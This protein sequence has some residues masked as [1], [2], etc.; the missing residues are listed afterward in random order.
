MRK[1]TMFVGMM[2]MLCWLPL[3][4]R[5]AAAQNEVERSWSEIPSI[6]GSEI[7]LALPD[8]TYVQGKALAIRADGLDM[9]VK[10]TSDSKLHP[11]GKT[12]I[13]R[14]LISVIELRTKRRGRFPLAAKVVGSAGSLGGLILGGV[15]GNKSGDGNSILIGMAAGTVAGAVGG[16]LLGRQIDMDSE[17]T[18]IRILSEP[19]VGSAVAPDVQEPITETQRV[20]SGSGVVTAN[21]LPMIS[22]TTGT[23]SL[24]G[25]SLI[26]RGPRKKILADNWPVTPS[27]GRENW[28]F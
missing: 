24:S 11:K 21:P 13:P 4:Q 28:A 17:T 26:R 19:T 12:T 23:P 15:L 2:L 7:S 27:R 25:K 14:A 1:Q 5:R 10:K 20:A 22:P 9:D 6:V 16:V 3:S 18:F 8:L